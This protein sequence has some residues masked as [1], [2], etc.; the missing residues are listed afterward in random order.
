MSIRKLCVSML[1]VLSVFSLCLGAV[2]EKGKEKEEEKA[3]Y[4]EG[5][6]IPEKR[7]EIQETQLETYTKNEKY[8]E[9]ISQRDVVLAAYQ[10]LEA[11][12]GQNDK[13][14]K[15]ALTKAQGKVKKS[16]KELAKIA[17]NLLKPVLKEYMPKK[18]TFDTLTKKA[19]DAAAK[20]N[21][22]GEEKYSQQAAQMNESLR[23][24]ENTLDFIYYNLYFDADEPADEAKEEDGEA[25][26]PKEDPK[27]KKG[28]KEKKE[29]KNKKAEDAE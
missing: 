26:E 13:N 24:Y 28:K 11:A 9:L 12:Q 3:R 29:K 19:E 23:S 17:K 1:C 15:K 21:E 5:I 4:F 22:K 25:K 27:E 6:K 7:P 2:K 8:A 14:A 10:E 18:K 16:R 20:N